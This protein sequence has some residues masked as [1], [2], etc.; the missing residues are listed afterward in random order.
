MEKKIRVGL[1]G[2]GLAGRVFHVPLL[3]SVSNFQ[4]VAICSSRIDEIAALDATIQVVQ[5][6]KKIFEDPSI[7]LV[8]IATPNDTHASLAKEALNN[9]KHVV[10]D[11]PFALNYREAREIVTLAE[12]KQLFLFAFHNRRWDSDFLSVRKAIQDEL[13]GRV[14]L[15]ESHLDRFR[16]IVRDRWKESGEAGTGVWW[17]LGPHL[18]DQAIC[19]FGKPLSVTADFAILREGGKSVDFS[20]VILRYEQCRVILQA[21][22]N[23]PDGMSGGPPRFSVFG[24]SGS[25]IKRGF[26]LQEAQ[27]TA[28]L[29]P[30]SQGW[31]I[32]TDELEIY[33]ELQKKTTRPAEVGSQEKYYEMV[34]QC[35]R[36]A[37]NAFSPISFEEMLLVQEIMEA[38][39]ISAEQGKTV[40][41]PL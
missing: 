14:A 30:G 6:P 41:L 32:D 22:L 4:L 5:E 37:S 28:G 26:D 40:L 18:I 39:I 16:P 36:G 20:H 21:N 33:D 15:F 9:G 11:K 27:L 3:Q 8:I 35:L 23:S 25:L 12:Q 31:G 24:R 2:Y 29:R 17:D 10:V 38:A 34:A 7:E 19:L 13:I 1:L